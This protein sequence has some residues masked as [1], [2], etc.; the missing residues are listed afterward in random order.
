MGER[1]SL[2]AQAMLGELSAE[3]YI[4]FTEVIVRKENQNGAFDPGRKARSDAQARRHS[5]WNKRRALRRLK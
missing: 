4:R 5:E 1:I 2:E 3:D